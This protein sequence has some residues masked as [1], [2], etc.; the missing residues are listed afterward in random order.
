MRLWQRCCRFLADPDVA[1]D[2]GTANTRLYVVDRGL[3]ADEPTI[4]SAE[5]EAPIALLSQGGDPN[6]QTDR[7]LTPLSRGV[8]RDVDA[9]ARLLGKLLKRARRFGLIKS[10]ALVC[11]PSEA[12]PNERSALLEAVSRSGVS[13]VKVLPEPLASAVGAGLDIS[14]PY[15]QM[16]ADI[17][18]GVT[19][20]AVIR[21]R[22]VVLARTLHRA[23]G[24][25]RSAVQ[26]SV[27]KQNNLFLYRREAER[28]VRESGA[29]GAEA[30]SKTLP[31]LALDRQGRTITM[32]LSRREVSAAVHPV[33]AEIV[34][35]IRQTIERLSP[36]LAVEV[37]E[38]GICLTGGGACLRGIDDVIASE[39]SLDVKIPA[40]PLHATINGASE[41][42]VAS[43][44]SELW[45][46]GSF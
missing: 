44:R 4:V 21:S 46:T 14:S 15:A 8:V 34:A 28:L 33:I 37:M 31:V 24:D 41:M 45:E 20:V 25:L 27:A 43:T 18:D 12:S 3:V 5:N 40:D 35:T 23:C 38:S 6:E 29:V 36:D 2:L 9:T 1:I 26:R 7:F 32:E 17:G 16:L 10:R 39:T 13:A 42:L 19:D 22:R 11:A 30:A